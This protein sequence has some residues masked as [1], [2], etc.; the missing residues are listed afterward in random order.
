MASVILLDEIE[1]KLRCTGDFKEV[2]D[3]ITSHYATINDYLCQYVMLT[4]GDWGVWYNLKKLFCIHAQELPS[5]CL[6]IVPLVGQFHVGY[7]ATMDSIQVFRFVHEEVGR[8]VFG[9]H[10]QLAKKPKPFRWSLHVTLL[11]CAW[12]LIRK[13][14]L[15]KFQGCKSPEYLMMIHLLEEVNPLVFLH[16][17]VIF[18]SGNYTALR[19]SMIRL[20]LFFIY[21][22]RHHYNKSALSW[23]SDD[24]HLKQKLPE[25]TSLIMNKVNVVTEKKVEIHHSPL[26][27]HTTPQSSALQIQQVARILNSQKYQGTFCKEY[28]SPYQRG[29]S[30]KDL[31]FLTGKNS[32][33]ASYLQNTNNTWDCTTFLKIYCKGGYWCYLMASLVCL[34][35]NINPQI[36]LT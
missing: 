34:T 31:T 10:Y 36:L 15:K 12:L 4:P 2:L 22:E 26:R 8:Y 29:H 23:I 30:E 25:Y 9:A 17:P 35:L 28:V 13:N 5:S 7:N 19:S 16:Y 27:Q 6:S 33:L 1:S 24:E 20:A 18:R 21:M 14:I 3:Y 11:H 32:F